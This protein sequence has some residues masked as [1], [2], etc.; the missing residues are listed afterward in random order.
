MKHTA[1]GNANKNLVDIMGTIVPGVL[2]WDDE[3]EE[4]TI[5]LIGK[6]KMGPTGRLV[7]VAPKVADLSGCHPIGSF[8]KIEIKVK[9]PGAKLIDREIEKEEIK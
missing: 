6:S 5:V 1:A 9:I 4:A 7:I 8:Q 2:E 3:T